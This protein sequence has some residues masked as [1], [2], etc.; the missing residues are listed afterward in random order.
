VRFPGRL[1]VGASAFLIGAAGLA[2][3]LLAVESAGLALGY[4]RSA[5]LGLAA[6][7]AGWASGAYAAGRLAHAAR[8]GVLAAGL[9]LALC[10][11][12][13]LFASVALAS[14]RPASLAAEATALAAI[15]LPAALS[16]A[17][18][19]WLV[20]IARTRSALAVV[21][22]AN[23]VGA[24][25]G[26]ELAHAV[27]AAHGRVPA[28]AAAG[29][30]AL[31]AGTC[32]WLAART[33]T[34]DTAVTDAAHT[35]ARAH[36]APAE[37]LSRAQ[38]GLAI[39]LVTVW[40][41]ALETVGLRLGTLWIGGMEPALAALVEA[42]LLALAVGA[43]LLPAVLPRGRDGVFACL[44]LC[45]LASLW[46][47]FA[48]GLATPLLV[49]ERPDLVRALALVGPAL[50]PFGAWLPVVARATA[51]PSTAPGAS[52]AAQPR[53]PADAAAHVGGL[54]VHEAWG[55]ALGLPLFVGLAIPRAGL[56]GT[57]ATCL[58]LGALVFLVL[59]R[60]THGASGAP[61]AIGARRLS[62]RALIGAGA[63]AVLAAVAATRPDPAHE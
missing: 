8:G 30:A 41:L 31:A 22:A 53:A 19:P 3:E 33:S 17:F 32:A 11:A 25:F 9:A 4:G 24:V 57:V 50:V 39:G 23:L 36:A 61:G 51:G 58:A 59:A 12:P 54:V 21:W 10:A 5:V 46:P 55:A 15:A 29:V 49:G 62:D 16:G 38:A 28:G 40:M 26:A 13:L 43:V 18:L 52:R 42:S 27:A 37:P 7:V 1:A 34:P 60:R 44:G 35:D 48:H 2:L 63:A 47:L 6:F 20:R 56:A 45:A 14:A